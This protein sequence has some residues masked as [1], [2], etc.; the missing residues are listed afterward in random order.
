MEARSV[1]IFCGRT[2]VSAVADR[3]HIVAVQ[4]E[5]V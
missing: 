5:T 2:V 4:Q 3:V 1:G